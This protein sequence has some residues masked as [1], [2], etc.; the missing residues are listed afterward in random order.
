M[1]ARGPAVGLS[2]ESIYT[3]V[4]SKES[5]RERG[6]KGNAGG[7]FGSAKR[8]YLKGLENL[9]RMAYRYTYTKHSNLANQNSRL[10]QVGGG[11]LAA[12]LAIGTWPILVG[13]DIILYSL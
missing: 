4:L 13:E 7:A 11:Q 5:I 3:I 9:S 1:D 10:I 12:F 2:K 8:S 6:L